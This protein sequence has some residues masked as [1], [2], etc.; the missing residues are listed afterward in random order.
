MSD[1]ANDVIEGL[2]F[3]AALGGLIIGGSL[4][5]LALVPPERKLIVRVK[6][7]MVCTALQ[8]EAV[9]VACAPSRRTSAAS[10]RP[11]AL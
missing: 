11:S 2:A 6:L 10:W 3:S 5:L 9:V 1:F 4:I 8:F 7:N